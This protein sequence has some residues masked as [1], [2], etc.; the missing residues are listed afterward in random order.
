[1]SGNCSSTLVV[2]TILLPGQMTEESSYFKS[3]LAVQDKLHHTRDDLEKVLIAPFCVQLW[4]TDH[5]LVHL[6][7]TYRQKRKSAE[8][9]VRTVS[10]WTKLANTVTS[11]ISFCED[12]CAPTKT[13]NNNKPWF[14]PKLKTPSP[15]GPTGP[16]GVGTEPCTDQPGTCWLWRSEWPRDS[17]TGVS[18]LQPAGQLRPVVHVWLARSKF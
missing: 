13:F 17:T 15:S 14:T 4:D 10:K 1:M 12:V 9:V 3:M 2:F 8:P 5:C 11:Y 18:K 16:T 7:P 6:S